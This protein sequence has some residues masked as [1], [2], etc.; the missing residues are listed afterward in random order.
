MC[1]TCKIC[2]TVTVDISDFLAVYVLDLNSSCFA[3]ADTTVKFY[4]RWGL[5]KLEVDIVSPVLISNG[6]WH[7]VSIETDTYNVRCM[8][9]MTEKIVRIP[10]EVPLIRMFSGIL[11]IGG[12][13][14]R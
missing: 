9:D 6:Q 10:E 1:H 7:Q 2:L 8:L 4:F 14:K 11:F 3:V 12:V 13:P 5:K